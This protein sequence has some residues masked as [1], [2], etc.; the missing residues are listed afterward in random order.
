VN[1]TAVGDVRLHGSGDPENRPANNERQHYSPAAAQA[2][3]PAHA[4]LLS[5][6]G[7]GL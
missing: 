4:I 1:H 3:T 2:L 5:S 6:A 7:R